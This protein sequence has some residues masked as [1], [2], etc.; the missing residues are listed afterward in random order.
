MFVKCTS[1]KI[2]APR[3][4]DYILDS[5]VKPHIIHGKMNPKIHLNENKLNVQSFFFHLQG[6]NLLFSVFAICIEYYS[7]WQYG[8]WSFQVEGTKLVEMSLSW[9]FL[10]RASPSC[11]GSELSRAELGRFNC[12]AEY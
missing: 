3:M 12:R 7:F 4:T 9:N 8:L 2:M 6:M 1:L 5:E 10:A 11:E